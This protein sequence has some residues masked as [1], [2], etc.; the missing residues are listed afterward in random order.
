[1][2]EDV[3]NKFGQIFKEYIVQKWKRYLDDCFIFWTKSRNDL[4]DFH[5]ILNSLHPSIRFTIETSEHELPFLDILIKLSNNKITTDIYY[6]KTDTHQYL[7]FHSCHPSHT[8]R[9]IPYCMARRLCAIV[10]DERL[11]EVRLREL[12]LFLQRQK[13][14][15]G[16]IIDGIEKAKQLSVAELRTPRPK[17]NSDIIPFVHTHDPGITNVFTTVKA[18]IPILMRSERI[19]RIIPHNKIID[20]RRQPLNLKRILSRAKFQSEIGRNYKVETCGDTRC[21]ICSRDNYNY[22]ETGSEKNI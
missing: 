16:I 7:N 5:I 20:S 9:N 2:Y 1:M 4:E 3:G 12:S 22:L 6:K 18:N 8:K 13:Y 21:G 15:L 17:T 14:P 19:K 11:R 10:V